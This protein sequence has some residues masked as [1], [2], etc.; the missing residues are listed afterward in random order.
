MLAPASSWA[1]LEASP[2]PA[3]VA[4]TFREC[5]PSFQS[6]CYHGVIQS[7]F[8]AV[9]TS[10]QQVDG[11]AVNALC[12]DYRT[13]GSDRWLLFQCVHGLG[14]GLTMLHQYHLPTAL[15]GCDLLSEAWDRD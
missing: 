14:H 6:G 10:G 3:Q 1:P 8:T 15:A 4:E 11:Q 12:A 2:S 7:Y 13:D 9:S 5:R